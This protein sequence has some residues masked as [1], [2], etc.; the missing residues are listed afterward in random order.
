MTSPLSYQFADGIATL[1]MDDGKAN[2]WGFAMMEA[3]NA[4]LD[5]AAEDQAVVVMS[6]RP[7]MFSGGFDLAVFKLG[8]P[9]VAR[10]LQNGSAIIERLVKFPRPVLAAVSGHAVAMGALSLLAFDARLAVA[11]GARIQLNETA[12]GMPLPYFG[13]ALG[14]ARLAQPH[15][16]LAMLSAEAYTPAGAIAAGYLDAI[17]PAAE[18]EAAVA[19]R[20]QSLAKLDA[21]AFAETKRRLNAP[22]LAA[23]AD[24]S[25]LDAKSFVMLAAKG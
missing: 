22:L 3:M 15:Q 12:I 17:A 10:M 16:S 5:R 8:G 25:Q 9:D 11:E 2:V 19:A 24:A 21:K 23:L 13:L 1:K 18:F 20:A 14:R 7:G 6:G 4:A